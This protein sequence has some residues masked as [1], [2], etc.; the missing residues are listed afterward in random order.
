VCFGPINRIAEPAPG[1]DE[2][3]ERALR[4]QYVGAA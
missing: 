4:R 2:A 1:F 3:I